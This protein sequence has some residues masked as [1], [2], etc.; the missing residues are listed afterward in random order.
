MR[1][2]SNRSRILDA[3]RQELASHGYDGTSMRSVAKRAQVDVRL[4]HHYFGPKTLLFR[5]ATQPG[6]ADAA[7]EPGGELGGEQCRVRGESH[8]SRLADSLHATWCADHLAWRALMASAMTHAP[9]GS[10]L[11]RLLARL[12]AAPAPVAAPAAAPVPVAPPASAPPV[13]PA[14]QGELRQVMLTS[15]LLGLAVLVES[16]ALG[17]SEPQ[18]DTTECLRRKY[19]QVQLDT[20][21]DLE[22]AP[23]APAVPTQAAAAGGS[24]V[25]RR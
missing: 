25:V 20:V 17:L 24:D 16:G 18:Q 1:S 22:I 5:A 6:R 2:P 23:T 7:R 9:A 19:L 4:V 21:L 13:P 10:R 3:A 8:G 14:D 15:Q 11:L 12:L